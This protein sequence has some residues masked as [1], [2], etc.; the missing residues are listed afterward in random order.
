MLYEVITTAIIYFDG[1]IIPRSPT[2]NKKTVGQY[3]QTVNDIDIY[4]GDIVKAYKYG[5]KSTEPVI[6]EITYRNGTY[7]F[8]NWTWIEFLK[9]FR[10]VEVVGNIHDNPSYNFV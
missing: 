3:I 1:Y 6:N 5:D 4:V 10:Y 2:V 8:S 7:M 9:V